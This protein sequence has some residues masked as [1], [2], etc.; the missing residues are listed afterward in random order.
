ML[1]AKELEA[2]RL[3]FEDEYQAGAYDPIIFF[4]DE[5]EVVFTL[6]PQPE[7]ARNVIRG[8]KLNTEYKQYSGL[9]AS[10]YASR[11]REIAAR[12]RALI[13]KNDF[14]TEEYT[15][16]KLA[17]GKTRDVNLRTNLFVSEK[18]LEKAG[19]DLTD[20]GKLVRADAE[21][22][23]DEWNNLKYDYIRKTP[24]IV[25][26]YLVYDD[27]YFRAK[28]NSK[29]AALIKI[30]YPDLAAAFPTSRYTIK[31]GNELAGILKVRK[32]EFFIDFNAPTL[33]GEIYSLSDL[34]KERVTL[35]DFWG[36]WCAPCIAATR[37]MLPVYSE[38]K[39]KGFTIIGIAR[40]FKSTRALQSKLKQEKY[41]WINLVE[42]DDRNHIWNKYGI[43]REGGMMLLLDKSGKIIAVDP[44][45]ETVRK[46]LMESL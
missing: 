36:T 35:V 33:S 40:E 27:I 12:Q 46:V 23:A 8:G 16:L 1:E 13:E 14:F 42:L 28:D 17:L 15:Q 43:S 25:S 29:L 38:F 22:L 6:Y 26:Y 11:I 24:S 32:G 9:Y 44:N 21:R 18:V 10:E 34:I 7:F 39:N 4:P 31:I 20:N 37:S 5:S 3:V 45:A 30:A 2:Y 19:R 41:P